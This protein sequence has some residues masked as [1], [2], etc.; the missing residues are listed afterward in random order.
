LENAL[1][2]TSDV[3]LQLMRLASLLE[4]DPAAAAREATVL[5][6]THPEYPPALLLLGRAHRL[7]GNSGAAVENFRALAAAQPDSA[8]IRL[9]LAR[10]LR[11]AGRDAEALLALQQAVQVSPDLAEGW[12]ELSLAHAARDET[13]ECD[14]AYAR[15]E[16]LVPEE[17]RLAEI[18][19]AVANERFEAAEAL[20]QRTLAHSP[21]DVAALRLRAR[22]AAT[23]EDYFEAERLLH[24]C[25]RLAPGYS[26]ARIELVGVLH[27]QLMGEPMLPLLER[28]LAGEPGNVRY[29]S[30]K[31]SAY[32]LLGNIQPAIEIHQELVSELPEDALVW[33]NY[34]NTLRDAGR[35]REAIEAYRRCAELQPACGIAWLALADLKTYR[36]SQPEVAAM[37]TQV[38][39]EQLRNDERSRI[40]FAL[41]KAQEDRGDF[42]GAFAH[43]AQGNALRRA[44]LPYDRTI[45]TAY[46]KTARALFTSDFLA[47]RRD[48]GSPSTAPIFIV[49]LPR[50][51]STLLEQILASHSQVEGTRELPLIIRLAME[52]GDRDEQDKPPAYP[53]S[54]ARLTRAELAALAARYLEQTHAYRQQ[55][56]R[57]FIDKMGPNFQHV[58]LIHLMFP[59]A[60]IIDAR[61]SALGCCFS[62]FKQ[63]YHGGAWFSYQ[64]EDLG[65]YY[66]DYVDLMAHFD[67]VL[68]GRIHRVRYESLVGDLEGEVRRLLDFCALPFEAQ[69]LRYYETRR[70]VAT[71]SS[72]QVRRPLY[73]D[74]LEQWRNFEPWLGPLKAALGDL[75]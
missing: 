67:E 13:A 47:A 45:A 61:R 56:R 8:V 7:A 2:R 33:L 49:G 22:I 27:Q 14:L 38:A 72:E 73:T 20:L 58:G 10:A 65:H 53:H 37:Q 66:R 52:L 31:A 15:F 23:R 3:D 74:S 34:G 40:E 64:L 11:A 6:R 42:A 16:Q 55:G 41:G 17:G 36:F 24:E 39:S 1:N 44:V 75:R 9:E 26:R 12:R 71:V 25:L 57:F 30:L 32:T 19:A 70:A 28:L 18:S 5:L 29:R 43:Y 21:Q 48:W 4:I 69:C 60:R 54:L 62:N 46:V 35:P 68:P 50:A 63:H 51:G 59:Q